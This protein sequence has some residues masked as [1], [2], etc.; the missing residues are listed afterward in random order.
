MDTVLFCHSSIE[1]IL[2]SLM[3]KLC[4]EIPC[5]IWLFIIKV[6]I[7]INLLFCSILMLDI[8]IIIL[9]YLLM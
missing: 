3:K 2:T 6:H 8:Q 5:G 1:R 9:T 4:E 7:Y